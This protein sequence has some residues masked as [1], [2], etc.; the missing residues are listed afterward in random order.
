MA[1]GIVFS[2]L[3]LWLAAAERIGQAIA[4]ELQL[5][6]LTEMMIANRDRHD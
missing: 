5:D 2:L 4:L 6:Q 3:L 1:N